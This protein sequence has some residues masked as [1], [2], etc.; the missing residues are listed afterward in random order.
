[1]TQDRPNKIPTWDGEPSGFDEFQQKVKWHILETKKSERPLQTARIAGA[2][3]GKAWKIL[4]D[5][6][7]DRKE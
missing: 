6:P 1:M 3:T 7:D 4:D 5:F 2:L